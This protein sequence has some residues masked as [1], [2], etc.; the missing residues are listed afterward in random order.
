[1]SEGKGVEPGAGGSMSANNLIV[2]DGVA[3][4]A[5]G[6]K[7]SCSNILFKFFVYI[8]VCFQNLMTSGTVFGWTP[9]ATMLRN[10]NV[11]SSDCTKG[12]TE[13]SSQELQLSVMYTV[14]SWGFAIGG[15]CFGIIHDRVGPKLSN[16]LVSFFAVLGSILVLI[17]SKYAIDGLFTP[18]FAVYCFGCGGMFYTQ[19]SFTKLFPGNEPTAISILSATVDLSSLVFAVYFVVYDAGSITVSGI[20]TAQA[21]I[22]SI[23]GVAAFVAIHPWD[24]WEVGESGFQWIWLPRKK[25]VVHEHHHAPSPASSV[26]QTSAAEGLPSGAGMQPSS[27]LQSTDGHALN[28][29]ADAPES[30]SVVSD[31]VVEERRS[32]DLVRPTA[33]E[34]HEAPVLDGQDRAEAHGPVS[35]YAE[36]IVPSM[37]SPTVAERQTTEAV[38]ASSSDGSPAEADTEPAHASAVSVDSTTAVAVADAHPGSVAV[39]VSGDDSGCGAAAEKET[40]T[41]SE[42]E[43]SSLRLFIEVVTSRPYI[44]AL[45]FLCAVWIRLSFFLST[46]RA[47]LLSVSSNEGQVNT[48]LTALGWIIPAGAL[49]S[50]LI[51]MFLQK[52]GTRWSLVAVT[53][54]CSLF[55]LFV[56]IPNLG[57]QYASFV[58]WSITRT[59]LFSTYY[60]FVGVNFSPLVSSRAASLGSLIM[61]TFG[62]LQLVLVVISGTTVSF[63]GVYLILI[64]GLVVQLYVTIALWSPVFPSHSLSPVRPAEPLPH[65]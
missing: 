51:G 58:L 40:D 10:D 9:L 53:A 39:D 59:W 31:I 50:P 63:L 22:I 27:A 45:V 46:A 32:L 33:S 44:L 14:G 15:F 37:D 24:Q 19:F 8:F 29:A 4:G 1:M 56:C 18:G 42:P 25:P 12:Q 6:S 5:V 60:S 49:S 36:A 47:F 57:L 26:N 62:L 38:E 54:L 43:I 13:C 16:V 2:K 11:F 20:F 65:P 30:P 48:A 28:G 21:V 61:S 23:F 17:A 7:A 64:S 41:E 52:Y 3:G 34:A 55:T 35:D